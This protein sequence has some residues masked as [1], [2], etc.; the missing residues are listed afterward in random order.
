MNIETK[1]VNSERFEVGFKLIDG[2]GDILN[3]NLKY[4]H[5]PYSDDF[6]NDIYEM[7][8]WYVVEVPKNYFDDDTTATEKDEI[9]SDYS[10]AL[11]TAYKR[12]ENMHKT[13]ISVSRDTKSRLDK[14]GK[15]NDSYDDILGRVLDKVELDNHWKAFT[16]MTVE[17]QRNVVKKIHDY[18][19]N[20][21]FTVEGKGY[22]GLKESYFNEPDV[23]NAINTAMK[24]LNYI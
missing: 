17:M 16:N 18:N 19:E 23:R 24:E 1:I 6:D 9:I 8:G 4:Y 7:D 5:D 12:G 15:K 14:L 3:V 20:Y 2:D 13:T 10:N 11:I 21:M 22:Y